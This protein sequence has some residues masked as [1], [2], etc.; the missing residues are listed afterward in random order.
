[1]AN[2]LEDHNRIVE[3][4]NNFRDYLI[5]LDHPRLH[6]NDRDARRHAQG[7][8][9][10]REIFLVPVQEGWR[11]NYK[12]PYYGFTTDGKVVPDLWH[13]DPNANGPSEEMVK[14]AEALLKT[15][16]DKEKEGFQYPV[17]AKE[18]RSWSNP[19]VM[20]ASLDDSRYEPMTDTVTRL[21]W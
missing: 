7:V 10:N 12:K 9:S 15:A 1:M 6:P 11:E 21:S 5:P 3:K 20:L 14:A 13:I 16:T 19:E 2:S 18:W 4:S 17:N 8:L